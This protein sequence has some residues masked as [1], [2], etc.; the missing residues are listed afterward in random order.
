LFINFF[1]IFLDRDGEKSFSLP[2]FSFHF[3]KFLL[4]LRSR[5]KMSPHGQNRE[6]GRAPGPSLVWRRKKLL[7]GSILK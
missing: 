4:N 1:F 2:S 5:K 6:A 7:H 3:I